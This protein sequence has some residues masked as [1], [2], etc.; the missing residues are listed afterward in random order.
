MIVVNREL[1]QYLRASASKKPSNWYKF[2][3]WSK[4]SY[5]SHS[6]Q[7]LKMSTFKALYGR[8]LPMISIYNLGTSK[9]QALD[10][11]LTK[12]DELLWLLKKNPFEAKN[13]MKMMDDWKRRVVNYEVGDWYGWRWS[14]TSKNRW[15]IDDLISCHLNNMALTKWWRKLIQ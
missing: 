11:L 8:Y 2:L 7:S 15:L 14:N 6:H 5:N 10:D 1:Q 12:R 13:I 9:V 4:F 3:S